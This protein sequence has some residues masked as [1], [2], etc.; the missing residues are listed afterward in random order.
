MMKATDI[1]EQ[2]Q[3]KATE[4]IEQQKNLTKWVAEGAETVPSENN[5]LG[6]LIR[7]INIWQEGI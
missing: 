7:F 3:Q 4:I 2:V 6:D 5:T 1:L